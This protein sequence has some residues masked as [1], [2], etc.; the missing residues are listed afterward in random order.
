[1]TKLASRIAGGRLLAIMLV[2]LVPM[3][4]LSYLTVSRLQQDIKFTEAQIQGLAIVELAM[5]VLLERASGKLDAEKARIAFEKMKPHAV[6][7]GAVEELQSFEQ[8]IFKQTNIAKAGSEHEL[9]FFHE[10]GIKSNLLLDPYAE[11]YA[12]SLNATSNI[13]EFAAELQGVSNGLFGIMASLGGDEQQTRRTVW[14]LGRLESEAKRLS[15]TI[16]HVEEASSDKAA[17]TTHESQAEEMNKITSELA[18]FFVNVNASDK[19]AFLN[20]VSNTRLK[21]NAQFK[22]LAELHVLTTQRLGTLLQGNLSDLSARFNQLLAIVIG[23]TLIALGG[24]A[25]L[26]MRTLKQLDQVETERLRAKA[27][28]EQVSVINTDLAKVNRELAEKMTSL[29]SAQDELINKRRMEQLGQLTATIAHEIRNPLGSVRTSAFLLQKKLAN[30]NLGIEQ[31]IDRI[32]KGVVR[33]D[34]IIT[35][36][37]DYS[38]TKSVQS[39]SVKFDDWLATIISEEAQRLPTKIELECELGLGDIEVPIDAARLQRAIINLLSN[40]SEAMVTEN[41]TAGDTRP[42]SISVSTAVEGEMVAVKVT[43][44]GPGISPENLLKVR[45]PL[46]TTKSFGTGLGIPAIEQIAE[47]HGGRL[48]IHSELGRGA[49]FTLYLPLQHVELEEEMRA[50]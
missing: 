10:I 35:Q 25:M 5:P 22:S 39:K 11:S 48:D 23:C 26:F 29:K 37:L 24:A 43:D 18:S 28:G 38:R 7:I 33:C 6:A 15:H 32:N 19:Q 40:A 14:S 21:L 47:Q 8:S 12:L 45:Q 1:M 27:M 44:A 46:F 36:L 17:Y 20:S 41:R 42:F 16:H 2:L 4:F 34:S 49:T 31:Q 50:A 13:P 3:L 30:K 9:D